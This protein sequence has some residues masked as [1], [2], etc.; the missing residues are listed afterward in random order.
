MPHHGGPAERCSTKDRHAGTKGRKQRQDRGER[1]DPEAER[2]NERD[3]GIG[4][5]AAILHDRERRVAVASTA[6]A[7]GGITKSVLVQCAGQ[8]R[9]DGDDDEGGKKRTDMQCDHRAGSGCGGQ[10]DHDAGEREGAHGPVQPSVISDEVASRHGNAAQE[11]DRAR[12]VVTEIAQKA[13]GSS[14]DPALSRNRRCHRRPQVR[15]G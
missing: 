10:D 7:V 3:G 8:Q 14:K 15:A 13:H 1:R 11:A 12:H 9:L 2:K 6:E 4:A 5:D